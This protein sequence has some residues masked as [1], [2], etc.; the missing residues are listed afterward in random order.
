MTDNNM[1]KTR[2]Q[3]SKGTQRTGIAT[4]N[5]RRTQS[6]TRESATRPRDTGKK[7]CDEVNAALWCAEETCGDESDYEC[8]LDELG[9]TLFEEGNCAVDIVRANYAVEMG[10]LI[11]RHLAQ[12]NAD[13][14]SQIARARC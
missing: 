7:A 8:E 2:L 9:L 5:K 3:T 6:A 11:K 13:I 4:R 1:P 14:E 12:V 10:E